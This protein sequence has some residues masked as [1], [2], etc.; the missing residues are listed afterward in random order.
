MFLIEI[1]NN[2]LYKIDVDK[3]D[4]I[5]RDIYYLK[6]SIDIYDFEEFYNNAKIVYDNFGISHIGYKEDDYEL[7]NNLFENRYK[8]HKECYRNEFVLLGEKL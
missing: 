4:Y 5:K 8:L 6:N 1:L 2:E 7:I 3:W